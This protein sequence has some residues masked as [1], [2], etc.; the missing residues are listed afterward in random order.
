MHYPSLTLFAGLLFVLPCLADDPKPHT[1]HIEKTSTGYQLIRNGKPYFIKGAGGDGSRE[2]L[3]KLGGN[4]IRTWGADKLD[5][6]LD[7]THKH[8]LSVSV[9]IWLGH[10]R[11]G[12]NYNDSDQVAE[13]Y[14]K[15]LQVIEKYRNHPAVLLWSIGN[16]ME[17]YEAGNNAAIWSA[18]NNIASAAKKIDPDHPTMTVVAEIGGARVKNIH[19][20]CPD[21]DI[22]GINSYGGAASLPERYRKAGG[23]KPFILTEYGPPGVWEIKKNS[24]GAVQEPTSTEKAKFY[25][26][27]YEKAVLGSNGLC[28]GSYAFTW[29]NKQEATATWFGL[30]LPDGT[31]LGATDALGELWTGKPRDKRCPII[32][33]FKLLGADEV[34][35][36]ST[37]KL[38]LKASHPDGDKFKVQWVLQSETTS[39]GTGGDSEAVPP[40]F[41]DAI[42][43]SDL[44]GAEI[45]A[46]KEG[47]IYRVFVYLKD[48]NGGGAVA[49]VPIRVK[50]PIAIPNG[51]KAKLPLVVYDEDGE[52]K[53]PYVP[54]GWMG[55]TKAMKLD[56]AWKEKPHVGKTCI[57]FN[58]QA[59][60]GWG[61]IVW[62]NP[63]NDWGDKPGGWDLTGAKHLIF[64][65]RGEEGGEKVSFEFGSIAKDKPFPDTA[66]GKLA[67]VTLTKDWK[68]YRIEL[69]EMDLKRIKTGFA[70]VVAGQGKPLTFYLDVIRFE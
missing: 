63:G 54:T 2:L 67:D 23:T 9:G 42:L 48:G 25:R 4:S 44:D 37:V 15:A 20:L 21:I 33:E 34:E 69:K 50:G 62:Q 28:L 68:E 56:P 18:I 49:N 27:V 61:G 55:N 51:R 7:E 3:A 8:G 30:L 40:T 26:T 12:F 13:Q 41:P 58:Y 60:D 19:R 35:P 45:K 43:K 70:F 6:V 17:G 59:K 24:F 65:A 1:V 31:R 64:Q 32:D 66:R 10:E 22:V 5:T 47:G 52:E 16:E 14:K 46:P 11:H 53:P 36:G 29:G 57:R 38:Q 39:F